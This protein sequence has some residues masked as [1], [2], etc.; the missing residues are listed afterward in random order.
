MFR[1]IPFILLLLSQCAE[2]S[3]IL[4]TEKRTPGAFKRV[5]AGGT[6]HLTVVGGREEPS[7]EVYGEDNVLATVETAI[8]G[9]TLKIG[10]KFSLF[11]P[12]PTKPI[13]VS[14]LTPTLETLSLSGAVS[15]SL[16]NL[17]ADRLTLEL[18]GASRLGATGRA[19]VL[20]L[21]LSGA[22][23]FRGPKFEAENAVVDASG[24]S[25]ALVHAKRTL[26]VE[27]SGA[28]TVRYLGEP[29]VESKLSGASQVL[30]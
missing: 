4:K 25:E 14:V 23:F 27:A 17:E 6:V 10:T 12:R 24:A 9:D 28:S 2:G 5:E 21:S 7:V 13:R 30:Q 22:S 18:S 15:G 3:G 29:K 1:S 19:G 20:R 8:E 11:A 26:K 16:E